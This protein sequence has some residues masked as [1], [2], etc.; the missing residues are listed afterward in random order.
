MFHNRT[1]APKGGLVDCGEDALILQG[2]NLVRRCHSEKLKKQACCHSS[3]S[4]DLRALSAVEA[5]NVL[6]P[7]LLRYELSEKAK[8][9]QILFVSTVPISWQRHLHDSLLTQSELSCRSEKA[10]GRLLAGRYE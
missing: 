5:P 7:L 8:H 1:P 10:A 4:E 3:F 9:F 2:K 6:V